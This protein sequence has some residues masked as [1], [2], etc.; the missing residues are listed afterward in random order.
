MVLSDIS[1]VFTTKYQCNWQKCM[2]SLEIQT[3]VSEV[4][5]SCVLEIDYFS[6]PTGE[7]I[8]NKLTSAYETLSRGIN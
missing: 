8:V 2:Y 3:S 1:E 5:T 4:N 7:R 6:G